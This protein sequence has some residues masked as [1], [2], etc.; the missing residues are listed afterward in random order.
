MASTIEKHKRHLA[1][2]PPDVVKRK[3]EGFRLKDVKM[4]ELLPF[5]CQTFTVKAPFTEY[6]KWLHPLDPVSLDDLKNWFGYSNEVA[7]S[8]LKE[9]RLVGSEGKLWSRATQILPHDLP[10]KTGWHFQDLDNKQRSAVRLM[11][12]NLLYGYVTP[13]MQKTPAVEGVINHMLVSAK[14]MNVKIFVAPDLI[15]CPDNVVE[16]NG[17][18]ALYFNNILIYGNGKLITRGNTSIHAVQIKRVP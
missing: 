15:I 11:S 10:E 17:L 8:L 14:I 3:L 7:K 12:K 9:P 1:V 18:A 2:V 13:E 4:E 16:F 6:R 5:V